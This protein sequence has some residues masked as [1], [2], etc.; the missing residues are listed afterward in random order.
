M[1]WRVLS[2]T[3]NRTAGRPLL[4]RGM[5]I[6]RRDDHTRTART[7]PTYTLRVSKTAYAKPLLPFTLIWKGATTWCLPSKDLTD[8][9]KGTLRHTFARNHWS[10]SESKIQWADYIGGVTGGSLPWVLIIDNHKSHV[11]TDFLAHGKGRERCTPVWLPPTGPMHSSHVMLPL[12]QPSRPRYHPGG[13]P[14][15]ANWQ[16][17]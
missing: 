5:T 13:G 15:W 11:A 17:K 8:A 7:M 2:Y 14:A 10:T 12:T 9:T 6:R 3:S 16:R 4:T 1:R